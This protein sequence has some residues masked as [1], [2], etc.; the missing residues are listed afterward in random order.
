MNK[1]L[2]VFDKHHQTASF[3]CLASVGAFAVVAIAIDWSRGHTE[4]ADPASASAL[5]V[6]AAESPVAPGASTEA[7]QST[8]AN[9]ANNENAGQMNSDGAGGTAASV[10]DPHGAENQQGEANGNSES[11]Q[12]KA[13]G[14]DAGHQS[15]IAPLLLAIL[16]ILLAAKLGG[17]LFERIGMP[18]V[19][20]ELVV[21]VLLGNALL[22][23]DWTG[24]EL[25]H[26]LAL[27]AESFKAPAEHLLADP[28]STG[29][30]LKMLA[31]IGVVLLLFEVGLETHVHEMLA[32]GKSAFLVAVLGVVAPSIL[33]YGVGVYF[34]PE[35]GWEVHSFLGAT[36]CATS[37][38]ITARVLKD[39]GR[40]QQRES[41]IIL[42]AAVI[43]DVL[44]LVVLAVVSGLV[45]QGANF[46]PM[47]LLLIVGK[48]VGFLLVAVMLG[49]RFFARPLY[50]AA[51]H[52]HGRGLLVAT[53]LVICFGFGWVAS[54]IGLDPIVGAFAAG[55]ILEQTHY[56]ELGKRENYSLEQALAPLTALLV[57]IFFVQMGLGVDLALFKDPAVWGLAGALTFVA[58]L[59]K[60]VCAFGVL[61]K[62]LDRLSVGIG[63]IPRGEVGLI[64][65]SIG[66][67]LVMHDGSTVFNNTTYSA[68][69][70][71]VILTTLITP[72]ILKVSMARKSPAVPP[73]P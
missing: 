27:G 25:L 70:V 42:G 57:P 48:A 54:Q 53:S 22:L 10:T 67:G 59:G 38:G 11:S 26:N 65:A 3:R 24:I 28:Y 62:G 16:V 56:R 32:V 6:A 18:A 14:E 50:L 4:A 36:L 66:R 55:L 69:V 9:E 71:M 44:G 49:S 17:D 73:Q 20:G 63:M 40:S 7:N 61:E 5:I 29:A 41:K 64:F 35:A 21:G 47:T 60:Q 52:L 33:G 34:L 1:M 13:D 23:T 51:N 8:A 45:Q 30:I 2:S 15:L 39:L 43:D 19:L 72:P 68:I 58:I 31:G 12:I 46:D 37:V